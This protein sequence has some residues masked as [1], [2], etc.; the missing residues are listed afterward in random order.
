MTDYFQYCWKCLHDTARQP[1]RS[2]DSIRKATTFYKGTA[3]CSFHAKTAPDYLDTVYI[4]EEPE[5]S[6]IDLGPR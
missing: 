6:S 4:R 2:K 5:L 1:A 3:L